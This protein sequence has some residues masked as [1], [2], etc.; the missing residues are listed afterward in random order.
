MPNEQG[1]GMRRPIAAASSGR[2]PRQMCSGAAVSRRFSHSIAQ[3]H[4]HRSARLH[5]HRRPFLRGC[6]QAT[7][8]AV[9][10]RYGGIGYLSPLLRLAVPPPASLP[11]SL[12]LTA[13][14][15]SLIGLRNLS[16]TGKDEASEGANKRWKR[17]RDGL[18]LSPFSPSL[19]LLDRR[20]PRARKVGMESATLSHT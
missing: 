20:D 19:L 13:I 16:R 10:R 15:P 6:P 8:S 3:N 9:V 4:S 2:L 12:P 7:T 14:Y 11:P 1:K 5:L 18:L 17:Q